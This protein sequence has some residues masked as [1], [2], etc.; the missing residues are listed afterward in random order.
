[1]IPANEGA[2]LL[3]PAATCATNATQ[4]LVFSKEGASGE[5]YDHANIYVLVGTHATNGASIGTL[6]I[7]ESDTSTVH[8]SMSS[9]VA[10]TGGTATSTSVGFVIPGA[11]AL[12]PGGVVEFQVDL[13]NRKKYC[14]LT[15]T[16]G[17]T[18]MNIAAIGRLTRSSESADSATEKSG[19]TNY[20]LGTSVT[21]C[22]KVVSG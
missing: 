14:G 20:T 7:K 9:I 21:Q 22:A 16:P 1:M 19:V 18:T 6:A 8:S 15:I 2:L 5:I 3:M 13:R 17:S 12:G 10:F 4:S 11:S